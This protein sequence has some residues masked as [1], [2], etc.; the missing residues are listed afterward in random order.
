MAIGWTACREVV[1]EARHAPKAVDAVVG[2]VQAQAGYFAAPGHGRP[3]RA[4]R[5]PDRP[6]RPRRREGP[7]RRGHPD[8]THT[9]LLHLPNTTGITG[10][11]RGRDGTV[12]LLT[13]IRGNDQAQRPHLLRVVLPASLG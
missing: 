6:P 2:Y 3:H 12:Y 13:D 8:H 11:A 9:P 4:A 10:L 1:V 5:R 7:V